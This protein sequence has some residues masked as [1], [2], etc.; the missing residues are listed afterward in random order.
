MIIA[1]YNDK[2][3]LKDGNYFYAE[4]AD[5]VIEEKIKQAVMEEEFSFKDLLK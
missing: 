3:V 2:E 5:T 4:L 1:L